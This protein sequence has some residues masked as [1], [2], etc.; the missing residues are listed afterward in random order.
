MIKIS[1]NENGDDMKKIIMMMLSILLITGCT[2]NGD[3]VLKNYQVTDNAKV[4][5][6]I[7]EPIPLTYDEF[8]AKI[9]NQDSFVLLMW[10]NGCGH[11]ETFEPI[12]NKVIDYYNI[13]IYSINTG[14]GSLTNEQYAKLENKTFITGTP[15][16]VVFKNGVTQSKKLV[17]SKDE[18]T[19]VDFLV[20]YGYLE[21][22]K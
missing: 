12:L 10:Q 1:Y 7:K 9:K 2:S 16:T 4:N 19:V 5:E 20:R 14:S 17:G 3:S 13:E 18:Q 6:T 11:C 21:E 22:I 8:D 15:T